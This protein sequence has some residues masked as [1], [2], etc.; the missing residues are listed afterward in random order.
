MTASRPPRDLLTLRAVDGRTVRVQARMIRVV[1]PSETGFRHARVELYKKGQ[2]YVVL[3]D[4]AELAARVTALRPKARRAQPDG[5]PRVYEYSLAYYTRYREPPDGI[6]RV[7]LRVR[8]EAAPG[9]GGPP[10]PPEILAR[11]QE[12]GGPGGRWVVCSQFVEPPPERRSQEHRA[13]QRLGN[14]QRRM[15]KKAPLFAEQ[16][17]TDQL[18]R[19]PGYF[20]G[21]SVD[22][23]PAPVR[24]SS[25]PSP[26]GD[27]PGHERHL[28]ERK[29]CLTP[30]TP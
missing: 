21:E 16:L 9:Q 1:Q 8:V 3:A 7:Q 2:W 10:T 28:Q 5:A 22:W 27:V 12:L 29:T 25:G 20:A 19:R 26:C 13:R 18:A 11:W 17:V 23:S 15:E 24:P 4:P 30:S 6:D 14:L